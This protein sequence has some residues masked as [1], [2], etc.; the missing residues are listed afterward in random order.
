[1]AMHVSWIRSLDVQALELLTLYFQI[2][3]EKRAKEE[4]KRLAQ[5]IAAQVQ[6]L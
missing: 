3:K 6:L 1:M 5:R 2:R 4:E